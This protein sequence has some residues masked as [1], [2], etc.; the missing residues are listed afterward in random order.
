MLSD[1]N[2]YTKIDLNHLDQKTACLTL[3]LEQ[4]YGEL[5]NKPRFE[6]LSHVSKLV[7]LLKDRDVPLTCFVQGQILETHPF[8]IDQLSYLDVEFELHSYSHPGPENIDAEY[9]IKR[10]KEAYIDFFNYKPMGYRFPLG[11]TS[12][13]AYDILAANEFKFSSSIFPSFR[14]GIFNNLN[15]PISPYILNQTR[16]VEFPFSVLSN[17]VRIPIALSYIKLLGYPY[18]K[19][20]EFS[21]LPSLIIFDFHMHDL[22]NLRT[23]IELPSDNMNALYQLIFKKIYQNT[24]LDGFEAF[25]GFIK[26]LERKGFKF[27]KLVDIYDQIRKGGFL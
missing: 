10:S 9:Q 17:I 11:A 3:D 24:G 21:D 14:P 16:I 2:E 8:Q 4:D 7:A 23:S 15:C 22:F 25:E 1:D 18:V 20:L 19:L 26:L 27:L 5:L 6:G 13:D 12:D